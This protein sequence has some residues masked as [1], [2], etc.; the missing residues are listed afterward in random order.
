METPEHKGT[1]TINMDMK[2]V[3]LSGKASRLFKRGEQ[4]YYYGT[5]TVK[6]GCTPCGSAINVPFWI[7]ICD[8]ET[9]HVDSRYASANVPTGPI[10][11][12]IDRVNDLG[13]EAFSLPE[14]SAA[15]AQSEEARRKSFKLK[16]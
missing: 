15:M 2:V 3:P 14:D 13:G 5:I 8:Y 4:Y 1:I 7:V 6:V 10:P 12:I 11:S 16:L 9:Y